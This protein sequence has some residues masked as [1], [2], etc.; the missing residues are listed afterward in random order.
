MSL[1]GCVINILTT[2]VDANNL[3]MIELYIDDVNIGHADL[4]LD[5]ADAFK[6]QARTS[7]MIYICIHEDDLKKYLAK[8]KIQLRIESDAPKP[9][10]S[11]DMNLIN[12]YVT[13]V[14]LL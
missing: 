10:K 5:P 7:N 2:G 12:T 11:I 6:P 13:K 14:S 1:R 8:G 4:I 3:G 9:S